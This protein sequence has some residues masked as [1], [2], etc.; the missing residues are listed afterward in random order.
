MRWEKSGVARRAVFCKGFV[1]FVVEQE[2]GKCALYR[3]CNGFCTPKAPEV[4]AALFFIYKHFGAVATAAG[5]TPARLGPDA[6][7]AWSRRETL[8]LCSGSAICVKNESF[9]REW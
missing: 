7:P 5:P 4:D 6:G 8:H 3:F 9:I 2:E 1:P